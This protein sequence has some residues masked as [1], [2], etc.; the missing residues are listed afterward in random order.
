MIAV[1]VA[2]GDNL[3]LQEGGTAADR[4]LFVNRDGLELCLES[5]RERGTSHQRERVR[6]VFATQQD[7][8]RAG[9]LIGRIC[10]R[11]KLQ[12]RVDRTMGGDGVEDFLLVALP[13]IPADAFG[14]VAKYDYDAVEDSLRDNGRAGVGDREAGAIFAPEHFIF[15]MLRAPAK[16]H[17]EDGAVLLAIGAAI[18]IR[19]VN[20]G[21]LVFANQLF[22]GPSQHADRGWIDEGGDAVLVGAE[23]SLTDSI[24]DHPTDG[25]RPCVSPRRRARLRIQGE[26]SIGRWARPCAL[27]ATRRLRFR[28]SHL[29]RSK[30]NPDPAFQLYRHR[31]RS[32]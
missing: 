10:L 7:R 17:G 23:N 13:A 18:G 16:Q 31:N 28:E 9:G 12:G 11:K 19:V 8:D 4:A 21:V 25:N 6:S 1:Q 22:R 32:V 15:A 30:R 24:E 5:G 3:L 14:D 27:G 2:V 26:S 29:L 20:D